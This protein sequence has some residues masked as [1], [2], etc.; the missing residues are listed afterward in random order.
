MSWKIAFLGTFHPAAPTLRVLAERGWVS[1]VIMP[2][3][4]GSKNDELHKIIQEFNLSWSYTLKDIENHEL[5]LLLAANYPKIVPSRYLDKYPCINT[6]WSDLPKYRGVH[7][8]AWSILNADYEVGCSVHWMGKEFDTGDILAQVRV[9]M[10]PEMSILDLHARLAEGQAE[11]VLEVL[12]NRDKTG[13][14]RTATQKHEL[15]TYVPLRVPE[16][17]IIDWTWPTERIWNL[18]RALPG[19]MYPGAFTYFENKKLIIWEAK[20]ADCPPYFST[21]GQV[22]RVIKGEGV[23]IKTGDTCLEAK[24]VGWESKSDGPQP[25]DRVLKRGFKLGY[26]PQTELFALHE[27]IDRLSHELETL[28]KQHT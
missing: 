22:V 3:E 2:E 18:V 24:T 25:A 1:I 11:A 16:D 20:P 28:K 6:H 14:W 19:P 21:P 13:E 9:T 10:R 27:K 15:A 26:H 23:W 5:N 12:E 4:A 8:T 7:S 17:G